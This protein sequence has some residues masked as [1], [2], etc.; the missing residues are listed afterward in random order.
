MDTISIEGVDYIRF[1]GL[2]FN[3]REFVFKSP[4]FNKEYMKNISEDC[5]CGS[6]FY[7]PKNEFLEMTKDFNG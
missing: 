1:D 4:L 6:R 7:Y 5:D 2:P 3:L